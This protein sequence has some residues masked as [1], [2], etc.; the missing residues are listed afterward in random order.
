MTLR[1]LL[2]NLWQTLRRRRLARRQA[3]LGARCYAQ[4]RLPESIAAYEQALALEP[5]APPVLINYG[6]ALYQA[7][8]KGE[9]RATWQ[10]TLVL[11]ET[12]RPYLAEQVRILLRQFG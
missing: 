5:D 10:R 12:M 7:G 6:L 4:G 2:W 3:R 9:A 11:T 1:R 8:R